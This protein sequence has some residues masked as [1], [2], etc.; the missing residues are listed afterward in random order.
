MLKTKKAELIQEIEEKFSKNPL[1]VFAEFKGLNMPD[2]SELRNTL[3]KEGMEMKVVKNTL[4]IKAS[5]KAGLKDT[6]KLLTGP[7]AVVMGRGDP[8]VQTR[9][10]LGHLRTTKIPVTI[11]GGFLDRKFMN[12]NELT[13]ISMLPAKEQLAARL[14]G[15]LQAPM[16]QFVG[17]LSASMRNLVLVLKAHQSAMGGEKAA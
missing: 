12:V 2:M 13:A 4:A 10:L 8:T 14:L 16:Y 6:E 5:E 9:A 3:R 15:Q 7:T 17:V 11:K 1:L